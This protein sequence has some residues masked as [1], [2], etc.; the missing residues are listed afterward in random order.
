[1]FAFFQLNPRGFYLVSHSLTG[2]LLGEDIGGTQSTDSRFFPL[3]LFLLL[4]FVCFFS[5][6]ICFLPFS[7]QKWKIKAEKHKEGRNLVVHIHI[8]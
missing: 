8:F 4:L 2:A 1:M 3:F 7:L 5:Q 6:P